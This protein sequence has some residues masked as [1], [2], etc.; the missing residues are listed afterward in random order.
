MGNF[1]MLV[2]PYKMF[3]KKEWDIIDEALAPDMP[4]NDNIVAVAAGNAARNI[5]VY[6]AVCNDIPDEMIEKYLPILAPSANFYNFARALLVK[7]SHLSVD[8]L[9]R[10]TEKLFQYNAWAEIEHAVSVMSIDEIHS[11]VKFIVDRSINIQ[12][13]TF[14]TLIKRIYSKNMIGKETLL[15]MLAGCC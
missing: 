8:P 4:Q 15:L 1:A 7:F 12:L 13:K 9:G 14:L 2:D 10:N 6:M 3:V 11:L 5:L